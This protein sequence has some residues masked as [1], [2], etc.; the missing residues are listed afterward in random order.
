[1]KKDKTK[2]AAGQGTSDAPPQ[3]AMEGENLRGICRSLFQWRC[4]AAVVSGCLLSLAFPPAGLSCLGW[5]ALVPLL[6]VPQPR[7]WKERLAVGYLFGYVHFATAL[8]W[9]NEVGFGAGY[10]LSLWCALFPACWY[11]LTSSMAWRL[12]QDR[13]RVK[14]PGCGFLFIRKSLIISILAWFSAV[15]WTS[16]EWIRGW[17][18][19]G[20]PWDQLGVS[21]W[22]H[23]AVIQLASVTGVHGVSCWMVGVNGVVCGECALLL[24]SWLAPARRGF[25]WHWLSVAA[26]CLPAVFMGMRPMA[27]PAEGTPTLNVLAVQGNQP[28]CREWT[29][30]QYEEAQR[31]Y[32]G[33]TRQGLASADSPVDLVLWPECAVP[34]PLDEPE[35]R[36]ALKTLL[37]DIQTPLLLGAIQYRYGD[38]GPEDIRL[39]NSAFLLNADNEV[40]D[41]Y[42]K[43][44]RVPFGEFT[45]LGSIFPWLVEMI[46]MGRD[47]TPGKS[48]HLFKLAK[49]AQAG[50]NICFEDAFP[51]ISRT[52]VRQGAHLL[53]TITNDSWYG[54]SS[55]AAQ[56]A[57][58]VVLRAVE[59]RRPF[60]R[61]GN[62]SHTCLVA[63][64]GQVLGQLRDDGH[65]SDFIAGSAVYAVPISDWGTTCY[66]KYGDWFAALCLLLTLG[67]I[68][69]GVADWFVLKRA[70][71]HRITA[72]KPPATAK[73][74]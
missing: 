3:G 66:T 31:T 69:K 38:G 8:H 26:A 49:G 70:R 6:L 46:G 27:Y 34:V 36:Y 12:T 67:G 43:V 60:L 29:Q 32:L 58:H 15:L 51:E 37:E 61:S 23:P 57:S 47:L 54:H 1:M 19:S 73:H 63:P 11:A 4:L 71:F 14:F 44:H 50:V 48:F 2:T 33:L 55:G 62:N 42:D 16:L 35:Y 30:E 5:I 21:Q 22:S 25:P 56:H 64:D 59:N 41:Y 7:L 53:M 17:L 9:L 74:P 10:L 18:L 39:F 13:G 65:D 20:F 40:I 52:F 24:Q 45:P 28:Q 68:G 72:T